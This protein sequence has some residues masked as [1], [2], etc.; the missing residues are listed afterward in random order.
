VEKLLIYALGRGLEYYDRPTVEK[1]VES[2][3]AADY[4][5]SVL[6][7]QIVKCDAFRQRRGL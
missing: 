3:P 7:T 5:F 4:K 1:I 6:V 2:L